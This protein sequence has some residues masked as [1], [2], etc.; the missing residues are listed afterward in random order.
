MYRQN[1]QIEAELVQTMKDWCRTSAK[2]TT[3]ILTRAGAP[4][5]ASLIQQLSFRRVTHGAE[6]AQTMNAFL[7]AAYGRLP[8][9]ADVLYLDVK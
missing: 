1:R 3:R 2:S 7:T 9:D 8:D 6:A 4:D 5:A